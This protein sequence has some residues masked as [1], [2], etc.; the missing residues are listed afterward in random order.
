MSQEK[1]G[2]FEP[3]PYMEKLL[4]LRE[5]DAARFYSL[6]EEVKKMLEKYEREKQ[7][8]KLNRKVSDKDN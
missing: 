7:A 1:T 5:S 6:P 3:D 8:A 4:A 2:E